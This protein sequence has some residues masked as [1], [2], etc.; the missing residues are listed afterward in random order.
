MIDYTW[1]LGQNSAFSEVNV[2]FYRIAF[3][4]GYKV[5]KTDAWLIDQPFLRASLPDDWAFSGAWED[6]FGTE[7]V[8][9]F[10]L[11]TSIVR[12]TISDGKMVFFGGGQTMAG[13][14][15]TIEYLRS[16]Y[17]E[18][19]VGPKK[20]TVNFWFATS[21]GGT[22]ITRYLDAPDFSEI[23]G[24]YNRTKTLPELQRVHN[25]LW[26]PG[27]GGQLILWQGTPGTGKTYAIRSLVKAWA[28]WCSSEYVTDPEHFFGNAGY[29]MQVL[30]HTAPRYSAEPEDK[31]DKW[32]LIV[33]EDCGELLRKDAKTITGQGLS[34]LL[35]ITDGMV[36]QGLKV[37]LL[38]TTNEEL[39]ALHDAVQRP[40]RCASKLSFEALTPE[41]YINWLKQRGI[42]DPLRIGDRSLAE[43]YAIAEDRLRVDKPRRVGFAA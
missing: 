37:I 28:P 17:P 22:Y 12:I 9:L 18:P 42:E 33:L 26:R 31:Q 34:R 5:F 24:N 16:K 4:K 13:L 23:E 1:D 40:G 38:M 41:H 20:I 10:D 32:K 27:T 3:G 21:Q 36:G 15:D 8:Y 30:L 39:G 25:P 2:D 29:M 11:G 14:S 7:G 19:N 43:L 6:R 35:N